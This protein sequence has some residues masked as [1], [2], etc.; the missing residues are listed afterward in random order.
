MSNFDRKIHAEAL[1]V[2]DDDEDEDGCHQVGHVGQ[3][4]AVEQLQDERLHFVLRQARA[5]RR[6]MPEMT[7]ATASPT[8]IRMRGNREVRWWWWWW[9]WWW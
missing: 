8:V 6:T 9:W 4:L 3:V 5:R 2:D 1:E 7:Y